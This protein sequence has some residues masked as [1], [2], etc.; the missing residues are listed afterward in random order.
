MTALIKTTRRPRLLLTGLVG[1]LMLS[2][3]A[4]AT[5]YGANDIDRGAIRQAS[6]VRPGI[7]TSVRDVTI[8]GNDNSG[9]ATGVGAVL[10]GLLGS[11][12]GGR[13]STQAIG[14]VGGAVL[15]GLAGNAVG[16]AAGTANGLA[17]VV[18]FENGE[19]REIVQGNDVYIQ[20]GTPVN[21]IF[22]ADGAIITPQQ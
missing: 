17:Y 16:R 9:I 11:Q 10:G 2:A 13:N 19:V 5:N 8:R 22:R 4:C 3:T 12:V 1:A 14:A 7:V 20:P 18:K 15:G 21:V 6:T